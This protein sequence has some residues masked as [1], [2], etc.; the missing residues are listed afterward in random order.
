MDNNIKVRAYV[1]DTL[2][3]DCPAHR[4]FTHFSK[5]GFEQFP[6]LLGTRV[7]SQGEGII[8][9]LTTE[10]LSPFDPDVFSSEQERIAA[11]FDILKCLWFLH[12]QSY[13]LGGQPLEGCLVT[14]R[15]QA[16]VKCKPYLAVPVE[17]YQWG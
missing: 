6:K 7:S 17:G 8:E 16:V 13:F 11:S 5:C 2:Q 1:L 15:Q 3:I 4:V 12:S 14:N 10:Q 9:I